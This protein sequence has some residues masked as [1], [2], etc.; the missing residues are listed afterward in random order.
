MTKHKLINQLIQLQELVV[1]DLQKK[2]V[3]PSIQLEALEKSIILLEKDISQP[4]KS[5]FNRLVKRH[6]E[7]IVPISGENCAGCGMKLTRS[8]INA[9]HKAE[10]LYRCP[11]CTRFLY[12]PEQLIERERV[13]RVYGE[14]RKVGIS[15]FTDL[16]L[17]IVPLKGI[18]P[19]EVL[20]ELA[21][22]MEQEGFIPDAQEL[23]ELALQR[24][25]IVSTAVD[26]GIAFPHVR[27]VEGGGLT[28]A[29]GIHKKGIKFGGPGR[30]LTR[31]FFFMVIPT[32]TSAFYLKLVSELARI[33]KD[34]EVRDAFLSVKSEEEL[35]K[36][37]IKSTRK[38]IK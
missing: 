36:L 17:M 1:A 4:V 28:M 11:N 34:K 7:A 18:T 2:T 23:V 9:V 30:T 21:R 33:F 6:V 38:N 29:V 31:I 26:Q 15:R 24:E 25:S 8:L 5:H 14:A 13:T 12:Y 37:L 32:A 22:R 10:D 3:M 20:S 27:G 16:E 19:E 35:W